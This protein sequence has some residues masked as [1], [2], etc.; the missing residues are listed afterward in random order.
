MRQSNGIVA[1]F[2]V[3]FASG[4]RGDRRPSV[5][6]RRA[7][8][9]AAIVA[10]VTSPELLTPVAWKYGL[11]SERA[12]QILRKAGVKFPKV[13][14]RLRLERVLAARLA[15]DSLRKIA[16]R[17]GI[18]HG[19]VEQLIIR[20]RRERLVD[21]L[22]AR[23]PALLAT[24]VLWSLTE[25]LGPLRLKRHREEAQDLAGTTWADVMA[26]KPDQSWWEMRQLHRVLWWIVDGAQRRT[27]VEEI[28][29]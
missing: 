1:A 3:A 2:S 29:E 13:D 12:R 10:E 8:R 14:R 19:R 23:D 21:G 11:T 15:G 17:E 5:A 9:D 24:P 18:S 16:A 22:V 4:W 6:D 25:V 7:E 20:A 27:C 28:G 26:R